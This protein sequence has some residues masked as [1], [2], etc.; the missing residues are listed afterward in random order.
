MKPVGLGEDDESELLPS[1]VPPRHISM[2]QQPAAPQTEQAPDET[3]ASSCDGEESPEMR[4]SAIAPFAGPMEGQDA[5]DS[6]SGDDSRVLEEGYSSLLD[7][8]RP[9]AGKQKFVRI[10]EPEHLDGEVEPVVI[11]PGRENAGDGPFARPASA[12]AETPPFARPETSGETSV[13]SEPTPV[14]ASQDQQAAPFAPPAK[15]QDPEETERALRAALATL[16]RMS[17]AA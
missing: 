14:A 4:E 16:Q 1:F 15:R 17:G 11:F 3:F 12:A 2:P 10:E 6:D 5:D 13:P 9:A 8:S 7:L